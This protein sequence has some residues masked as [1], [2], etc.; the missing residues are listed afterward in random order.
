M[1]YVYLIKTR[2]SIKLNESIY[3]IGRTTQFGVSRLNQYPKGSELLFHIKCPDCNQLE[4]E[5]KDEFKKKYVQHLDYGTEYFQ[6]DC[7]K[8]IDTMFELVKKQKILFNEQIKLNNTTIIANTEIKTPANENDQINEIKTPAN[9]NDQINDEIKTP[10]N[11]NDQINDEIKTPANENDQINTEIVNTF[12]YHCKPCFKSF[13]TANGLWKHN[14][15]YHQNDKQIKLKNN[16]ICNNCN[17]QLSDR[18]SK[19]RH[20]K[21]CKIKNPNDKIILTLKQQELEKEI[22]Q[23]KKEIDIIKKPKNKSIEV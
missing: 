6:G 16:F 5:I 8:M 4:K 15:K 7:E 3:K 10:A 13:K 14:K 17:K 22:L 18:H 21:I 9:E 2:E 1:S 19:W 20:E 23:L 12:E 11:E